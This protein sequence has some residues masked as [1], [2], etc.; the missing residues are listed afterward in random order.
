MS[1]AK[2]KNPTNYWLGKKRPEIKGWLSPFSPGHTP[3]NKGKQVSGMSGKKH[4]PET[5]E[6]MKKAENS[7]WIKKGSVPWCSGMRW[8]KSSSTIHRW[9]KK[10]Y[11]LAKVCEK[12]GSSNMI[13]WSNRDHRYKL[14][15]KYWQKLCR[16]CHM[17]Y[18]REQGLSRAYST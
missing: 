18:D 7:G 6:K 14:E 15:R 9:I 10:D 2:K 1:I 3:W 11:G 13:E 5:I 17:D 8:G 12:C 16:K 4:I